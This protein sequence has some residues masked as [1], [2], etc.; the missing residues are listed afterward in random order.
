MF[1][2]GTQQRSEYYAGF[3]KAVAIARS[4]RLGKQPHGDGLY[5]PVRT[6]GPYKTEAAAA[7]SSIGTCGWARRRR[8]T[9][10]TTASAPSSAGGSIT[11]AAI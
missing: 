6:G 8:S 11:P 7:R 10:A 9:T 5:R 2:A 4:G 1:Q 3:L